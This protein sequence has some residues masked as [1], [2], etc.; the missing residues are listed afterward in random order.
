MQLHQRAVM[1]WD[2]GWCVSTASPG[3]MREQTSAT[4]R[5]AIDA[6]MDAEEGQP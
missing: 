5:A 2:G 1:P 3:I 4:L 6:A